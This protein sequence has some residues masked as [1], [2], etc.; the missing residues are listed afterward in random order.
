GAEIELLPETG[1]DVRNVVLAVLAKV[2]AVRVDDSSGVVVDAGLLFLI[3]RHDD[4]HLVFLRVLLHQFGGR[5]V[6]DVLHGVV[7][8]RRLLG[9]EIWAGENLLHTDHLYA[10]LAG[11]IDVLQRA[12]DLRLADGLDALVGLRGELGLDQS[13]FHDSGHGVSFDVGEKLTA[14]RRY[15]LEL[16]RLPARSHQQSVPGSSGEEADEPR[17][18]VKRP[19]RGDD[20]ADPRPRAAGKRR[21][22]R[23]PA[24]PAVLGVGAVRK[25]EIA[26]RELLSTH[27]PVVDDE[28]AGD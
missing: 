20:E 26:E 13:A 22:H 7:P 11:L 6:R 23:A 1:G 14:S 16:R 15:R 18:V 9:A 4:D 25:I 8:A 5:P 24:P 27:D 12:L 3:D 19:Q 28:N 21:D 10:L 2:G 17:V